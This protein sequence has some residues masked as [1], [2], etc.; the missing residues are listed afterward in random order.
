MPKVPAKK[1]TEQVP[2]G[3]K[4]VHR[5]RANS[6]IAPT[7]AER[8]ASATFKARPMPTHQDIVR[9]ISATYTDMKSNWHLYLFLCQNS[10]VSSEPFLPIG[11]WYYQSQTQH[12]WLFMSNILT[13][14]S[15][16]NNTLWV[17]LF[18][19]NFLLKYFFL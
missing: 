16:K 7:D 6:F 2:F 5:V 3:L 19:Q 9:T 11:N 1:A 17:Y 10:Y 4:S 12:F 14:L 18:S 15:A 8:A 13:N